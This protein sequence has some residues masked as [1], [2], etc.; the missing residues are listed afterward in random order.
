MWVLLGGHRRGCM[1]PQQHSVR[2]R[3]S[4]LVPVL[5]QPCSALVPASPGQ[6]CSSA[7]NRLPRPSGQ[8][9]AFLATLPSWP[10]APAAPCVLSWPHPVPAPGSQSVGQLASL[11]PPPHQ[12]TL[13]Q[14]S[15]G[16][17]ERQ[18][19]WLSEL[20]FPARRRLDGARAGGQMQRSRHKLWARAQWPSG[21]QSLCGWISSRCRRVTRSTRWGLRS[22]EELGSSQ[23]LLA[24]RRRA[25]GKR[26]CP[27]RRP[28]RGMGRGMGMGCQCELGHTT[29]GP[30]GMHPCQP[31][32]WQVGAEQ[33]K[34]LLPAIQLL[35]GARSQ[36]RQAA[37]PLPWPW[38]RGVGAFRWRDGL[39]SRRH[40]SQT[41]R[42]GKPRE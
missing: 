18:R 10:L 24:L 1:P 39:G 23:E 32:L 15:T 35:A 12:L 11:S 16:L 4:C 38:V 22:Q 14:G 19:L 33:R 34:G 3:A 27:R 31:R 21:P 40:R 8:Q 20:G 36:P 30:S 29:A 28:S 7:R 6:G 26:S 42:A 17:L 41:P 9:R 25:G 5:C 2:P 13:S 37:P